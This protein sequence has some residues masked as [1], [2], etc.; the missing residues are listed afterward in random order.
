MDQA[1]I[2]ELSKQHPV[3]FFDGVCGLCNGAVDALLTR[4]LDA[5]F[6]FAPLQGSSARAV[7]TADECKQ[8]QTFVLVK[9]Q[10]IYRR[11]TAALEI[12]R[13]L[14]GGWQILGMTFFLCP[15]FIRDFIYSLVAKNRYRVWGK[16]DICRVP[17]ASERARF[18][19]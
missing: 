9:N 12:M 1:Q 19:D 6:R 13:S 16:K 10:Q 8:L 15:Q 14:G 18:L 11:S 7:L 3:I 5:H 4:D 2:L 17:T